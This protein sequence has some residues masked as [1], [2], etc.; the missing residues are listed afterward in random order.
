M[1]PTVA[2]AY[3]SMELPVG[4][5]TRLDSEEPEVVEFLKNY[6]IS[7][8]GVSKLL[9][10]YLGEADG[11]ADVTARHFLKTSADWENWVSAD[12]A[13]KVKASL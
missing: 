4:I 12:V 10:H 11:E 9:V 2:T 13:K 5:N 1:R 7:S 3:A 8:A 6:T